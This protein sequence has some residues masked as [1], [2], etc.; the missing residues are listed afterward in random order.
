MVKILI[1]DDS[2][3][4]QQLIE[5][6]IKKCFK[7]SNLEILVVD[8]G[9]K[10]LQS[11]NNEEVDIVLLDIDMNGMDGM[12]T[13][14]CLRRICS[15]LILIFVTNHAEYVFEALQYQPFRYIR[16]AFLDAELPVALSAA[17]EKLNANK[18]QYLCIRD[19]SGEL[20]LDLSKVWYFELE[21]RKM[22]A[23]SDK[24][25]KVFY[26]SMKQLEKE[27]QAIENEFVKI[28]SGCLVNPYYVEK[29]VRDVIIMKNET[30]LLMSRRNIKTVKEKIYF[31]WG[32]RM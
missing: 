7:Q 20:R 29:I 24:E 18:E 26:C 4:D 16:K 17:M 1:C 5:N 28:Y 3:D 14:K 22:K 32:N 31:Y 12:E 2:I 10:L 30:K 11:I 19:K 27:L 21:G 23:V 25:E 9:K 13:A 15:D 8:S 6:K